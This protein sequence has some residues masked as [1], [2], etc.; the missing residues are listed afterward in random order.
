MEINIKNIIRSNR[1][2]FCIEIDDSG[3]II[4]RIPKNAKNEEIKNFLFKHRN[5]IEKKLELVN[6]KVKYKEKKFTKKEKFLFLGKEYELEIVKE[7][8]EPIIF[9]DKFLLSE[10]FLPNAKEVFIDWYKKEAYKII[11]ER[12]KFYLKLSNYK[13]NRIRITSANKRW[14]SCS[15]N[16]NLNFSY[17]LAMALI[18]IIDYV[19]VHEIIHLVDKSHKKSFYEKVEK[20]LPDYKERVKWLNENNYLLKI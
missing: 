16:G 8:T 17:R 4:L 12:V 9:K 3:E 2:S 13:F 5:W 18:E 1:K 20:I 14:G 11:Y 10:K 19:V 7:Q 15:P 6:N